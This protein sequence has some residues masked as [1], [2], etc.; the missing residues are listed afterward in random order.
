MTQG[1]PARATET[2]VVQV[3]NQAF[4][5]FQFGY[6][7]AIGMTMFLITIIFSAVYLYVMSKKRQ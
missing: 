2:L 5:Y 3:Y 1:G 6:G 7:S 4:K